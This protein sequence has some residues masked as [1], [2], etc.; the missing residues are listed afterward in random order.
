MAWVDR[1]WNGKDTKLIIKPHQTDMNCF[2]VVKIRKPV[3]CCECKKKIP[4]KSYAYGSDWTRICLKC[5]EA[6]S[7]RAIGDFET[8]IT[9]IK[10]N[11]NRLEKNRDKWNAENIVASL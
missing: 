5:G 1:I 6:F 3:T 2:R 9:Y 11:L 10:Q 8:I 4:K 7:K